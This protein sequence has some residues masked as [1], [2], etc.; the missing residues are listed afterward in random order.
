MKPF[1]DR[2]AGSVAISTPPAGSSNSDDSDFD[3]LGSSSLD[4]LVGRIAV[5][6]SLAAAP[7][8]EEV[9]CASADA[10]I[11]ELS[12]RVYRTVHDL[13]GRLPYT[14]L[15]EV[16][17]NLIHAQ[18]NEPVISI[19]ESGDTVRFSDQGP[20]IAN[21]EKAMLPGYT[22]ASH[23][24]KEVIRGV[25]SGL[26]LVREF[27]THQ[28]GSLCLEDNL[29]CGTVVTLRAHM[30]DQQTSTVL[31]EA[32]PSDA[33]TTKQKVPAVVLPRLSTR[34]KRV[35]SIVMEFG[36]AGPTLISKEL[37]VG[38]STAYRDLAYLEDNGLIVSDEFG[39]RVISQL[40][41]DYLDTIFS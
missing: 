14:V 34:Q 16:V 15:R 25:G 39:K 35:L 24:M 19:L 28:G 3:G 36:E 1:F 2:S 20:G 17:E 26:P 4:A 12:A 41:T 9:C 7:R 37:S 18:F 21:K 40:G 38:L 29:G 32:P 22:T 8:V 30:G 5:Y 31:L 6:D 13:N 11:E 10:F 23:A 33:D 27:L